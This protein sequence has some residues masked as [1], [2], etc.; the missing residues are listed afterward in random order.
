MAA[1]IH[2]L[3]SVSSKARLGERVTIKAFAVV[4]DDVELGDDCVVESHAVLMDGARVG[5][6]NYI[7]YGAVISGPPQDISYKNE[8]TTCEIGDNNSFREYCTMHR[9]TKATGKTVIGSNGFFMAYT[10]VAH[11]CRVG[12]NVIFAN[13]VALGGHVHVGNYAFIGGLTPVHQFCKIGDQVMIGGGLRVTKDVPPFI[14]AGGTPLVFEGLNL[15]GL[16]RRGFSHANIELIESAFEILYHGGL[17]FSQAVL[18]LEKRNYEL[19]EIQ[20]LIAFV[21]E[22]KRGIIPSWKPK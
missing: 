20:K 2:P 21:K 9:G 7:G 4:Q 13:C 18:E 22:S 15:I 16:R 11:D 1:D 19:P 12:D 8:P 17:N 6:N 10:H 14:L 3:A 5:K